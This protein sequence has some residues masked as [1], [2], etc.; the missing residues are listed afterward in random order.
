VLD[1]TGGPAGIRTRTS[2]KGEGILSREG[3]LRR[4]FPIQNL[5]I[6]VGSRIGH[7]RTGRAREAATDDKRAPMGHQTSRAVTRT[8]NP[9]DSRTASRGLVRDGLDGAVR[10]SEAF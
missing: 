1:I 5:R 6:G 7:E 4:P 3:P 10:I 2:P 9:A 8:G